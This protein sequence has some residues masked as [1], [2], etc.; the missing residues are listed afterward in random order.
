MISSPH[1]KEVREDE[2]LI[3]HTPENA[4]IAF[5][6][7][8]HPSQVVQAVTV[9]ANHYTHPQAV[10]TLPV[11]WISLSFV[12]LPERVSRSHLPG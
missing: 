9:P 8:W 5:V 7:I 1:P 6:S 3:R 4:M 11:F 10:R 12:G 2:D